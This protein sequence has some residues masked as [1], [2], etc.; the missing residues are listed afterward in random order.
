MTCANQGLRKIEA[1][2]VLGV[3]WRGEIRMGKP[4]PRWPQ[5]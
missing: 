5:S 1:V 3:E 4:V 2:T